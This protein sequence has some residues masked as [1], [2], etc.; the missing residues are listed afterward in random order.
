MLHDLGAAERPCVVDAATSG[1]INTDEPVT[2][3]L[4][5]HL[6]HGFMCNFRDS[7]WTL[8]GLGGGLVVVAVVPE[9]FTVAGIDIGGL[10][11]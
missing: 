6:V 9:V 8:G 3:L 10:T 1:K 11:C 5:E 2:G 7:D 4:M